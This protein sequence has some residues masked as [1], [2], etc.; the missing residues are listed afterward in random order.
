VRDAPVEFVERDGGCVAYQVFGSG[1][2]D[3]AVMKGG[4][5]PL[6]LMWDLPQLA[7]FMQALG[8]VARVIVYDQ[9][10]H[11]AADPLPTT[12]GA[13][14]VENGAADLLA[15][16]DAA[17][18]DRACLMDLAHGVTPVFMA[19][20][21]PE[22]V[23][24]IVVAHLRP[25]FP[26]LRGYS[27]E[28]RRRIALTLATPRGLQAD[29]PR[30]AHDVELRR[31]WARARR[32]ESSPSEVA[33]QMEWAAQ[34][35]VESVL[36]H[37]RVPALVLHRSGCRYDIETSRDAA[38][39]M[40]NCRFVELPGTELDIFLGDTDS[41]LDEIIRFLHDDQAGSVAHDRPLATVLFTDIVASTEQLAAVGDRE[42]RRR[43][44]THDA[45]VQRQVS[46]H[47]GRLVKPL[48]D[49]V[50]ATF[51]G[52]A[53]AVRCAAAIREALR[54]H[55]LVIRAGLHT[56]EIE[57]RKDD[58]AGLAVH[59]ASRIAALAASDEIL[60]SRTV[61][62]LT[63]G[64]G[65]RFAPRGQHE[66]KGVP[67]TWQTFAAETGDLGETGRL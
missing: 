60:V 15:V 24:S 25:S 1:P 26:E 13:A 37:V 53:R 65:L 22:R 55:G 43:L 49:G 52:P 4:R 3:V 7:H 5:F 20:T 61:V 59:I 8:S 6:D 67:G 66:L 54:Q 9:R 64:S 45:T 51:D 32:L 42:W 36:E 57:P 11:G 58:V 10:G 38:A 62:D 33:D 48:G 35:D 12:N 44:D 18:S 17:R 50:L 47:R 34:I 19:A 28:Q 29:N 41:V 16:M 63:S 27:P 31:W 30:V 21:Y 56:G 23:Q 2:T 39:R 46:A 14:G 40:S